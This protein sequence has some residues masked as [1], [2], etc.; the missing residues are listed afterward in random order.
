M[1]IK[2]ISIA[3]VI[4]FGKWIWRKKILFQSMTIKSFEVMKQL[5]RMLWLRIYYIG[6]LTIVAGALVAAF[7][8]L[9]FIIVVL[10]ELFLRLWCWLRAD[11]GTN[12]SEVLRNIFLFAGGLVGLYIAYWR[13]KIA[14][15]APRDSK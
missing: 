1:R 12:N 6:L 5:C 4:Q 13:S 15:C 2:K 9:I 7:P 14:K 3:N 10:S 11:D 8:I